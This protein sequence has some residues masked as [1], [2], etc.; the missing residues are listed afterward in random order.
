MP[1]QPPISGATLVAG[2]IGSPVRHSLSPALHNA[3]FEHLGLDWCFVAFDVPAGS[4][5]A[6]LSGVWA[7]GIRGLSVTMPH[8]ADVADAVDVVDDTARALHAVNCVRR[9]DDGRLEGTNTDGPGFVASLRERGVEP[10]GLGVAVVGAGGAARAVV[11]ALADAGAAAVVVVNRTASAAATAAALAGDLGSVGGPD[12]IARADLVVHAT[13]VGMAGGPAAGDLAFDPALVH[14]G[15]VVADLVYHPLDT[16]L[17]QAA[18]AQGAVT[19]DGLGMLVHQAAI[20]FERWT[21]CEAPVAAMRAA[22][23]AEL[24]RRAG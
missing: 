5:A 23:E 19:V 8:K 3:A 4:A 12:A 1:G 14:R 13:S 17:L 9:L 2:V 15:Q 6:A 22:A 24:A 11:R 16:A 10:A 18:R 20:A 21:G 7:L